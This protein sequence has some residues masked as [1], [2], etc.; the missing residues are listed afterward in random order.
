MNKQQK[1]N[2]LLLEISNLSIGF[3]DGNTINTAVESI[4]FSLNKNETLAIVGESGSGKSVTALS[5]MQLLPTP[6][7]KIINGEIKYYSGDK[8]IDFV[9]LSE[10]EMRKYR[11]KS[12]AMIFQEPMTSLNP[13]KT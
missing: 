2:E 6:T 1:K 8:I 5:I 3:S 13:V 12:V 10:K 11:V 7:G 9:K 4:S